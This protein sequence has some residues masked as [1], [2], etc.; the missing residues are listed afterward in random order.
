MHEVFLRKAIDIAYKGKYLTKPNPM[1]GC[2]IVKDNKVIA[3]GYHMKYG[4]NHAEINA[5]ENLNKNNDIFEKEL[6][7]LTL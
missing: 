3:D 2:V 5:L 1:V 6:R 7:Q 4:S